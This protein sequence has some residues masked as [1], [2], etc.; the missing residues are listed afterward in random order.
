GR[1]ESMLRAMGHVVTTHLMDPQLHDFKNAK[2]TG[3]AD[4]NGDTAFDEDELPMP[5]QVVRTRASE[6]A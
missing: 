3:I 2:A 1:I 5:L 4:P 6:V